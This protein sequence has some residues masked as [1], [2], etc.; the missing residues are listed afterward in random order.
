MSFW[1]SARRSERLARRIPVF[2]V[3]ALGAGLG[4]ALSVA[5][6]A[7]E[8][9][10]MAGD[11]IWEDPDRVLSIPEPTERP[12]SKTIDLFQKPSRDRRQRF[13]RRCHLRHSSAGGAETSPLPVCSWARN[14]PLDRARAT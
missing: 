13:P 10:F 9:R 11:P 4:L 1:R 6:P 12:L 2:R 8:P 5:V 14:L 3:V 7:Q